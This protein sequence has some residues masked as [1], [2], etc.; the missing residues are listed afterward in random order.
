MPTPPIGEASVG[1]LLRDANAVGL[2]LPNYI[3]KRYKPNN[4]TSWSGHLA[5]ASE[6]IQAI[7]PEIIVEL[8]THW[9]EAYFTFCQTVEDH[10]VGSLC[11][12][13]DHWLGDEHAGHYGEEV[14][15]NVRNYNERFYRQF[16]YLLRMSFDDALPQF[17]DNSIGLLHV[18]G[19]HTYEAARHDFRTWLPKVRDGGIILL[20]DICPKH[21]DFGVWQLWDEIKAEFPNTFEFHHGWGLGVV[22]KGVR[23]SDS[24]LLEYLFA[25][26]PDIA[27][28][29]RRRY[30]I[31]SS[32]LE[33]LLKP[34]KI[35]SSDQKDFR[36]ST[37]V[38]VQ[39]F[40]FGSTGYSEET[41]LLRK[42]TTGVWD[43]LEFELPQGLGDGPLRIDPS[44][45]PSLVQIREMF[46]SAHP[47][48]ELVWNVAEH[49]KDAVRIDG[50][51]ILL[52]S[53]DALLVSS[54]GND[55]QIVLPVLSDAHRPL[56]LTIQ[57][58]VLPTPMPAPE[59][60]SGLINRLNDTAKNQNDRLADQLRRLT[61]ERDQAIASRVASEELL[62]T[63]EAGLREE[64]RR[65]IASRAASEELLKTTE[66][67]LREEQ[68]RQGQHGAFS[69]MARYR[70]HT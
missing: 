23:D 27:E 16:S 42:T 49:G 22:Q 12:A 6:L 32:H 54:F 13:V 44:N 33:N 14:F 11:Y 70:S 24:P 31:Y 10:R 67:S 4:I 3:P 29:I 40:P 69:V 41:G 2:P 34:T 56:K 26:S 45:E 36:A 37:E 59:I 68:D 19:F 38:R 25:G 28:E 20:H 43:T 64:L 46:L 17:A 30:V 18:D 66:A 55:P 65:A 52:P 8:G 47:T 35:E 60:I 51:A 61:A 9:G 48:G 5:F 15:E 53:D 63:T 1:H 57:L 62:K 21:E 50:T 7:R 39:V 58:R